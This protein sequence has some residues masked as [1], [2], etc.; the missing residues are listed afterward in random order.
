V[1]GLDLG[2]RR[3]VGDDRLE[4]I[5]GAPGGLALAPEVDGTAARHQPQVRA[6]LAAAGVEL[7]RV[8]PDAQE[9]VLDDV[10]G[11]GGAVQHAVRGG[12]DRTPVLVV[13]AAE[14]HG[15]AEVHLLLQK[16]VEVRRLRSTLVP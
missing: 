11:G 5:L 16:V 10:L 3:L 2:P 6:E 8:A 14:G 7:R 15:I 1:V 9:H 4:A 12:V 13:H